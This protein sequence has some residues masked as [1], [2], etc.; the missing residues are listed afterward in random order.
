M[1]ASRLIWCLFFA[2]VCGLSLGCG[3][4]SAQS[5]AT[6]SAATHSDATEG[7]VS[8]RKKPRQVTLEE[9]G[10]SQRGGSGIKMQMHRLGAGEFD[11]S[12][13]CHASSTEGGYSVSLPNVFVDF[14]MTAIVE[15]GVEFNT[16]VVGTRDERLVKFT[17]FKMSRTDGKLKGKALEEI[18]EDFRKQGDLKE[19]RTISLGEM[20]G[21]EL[22]VTN[23]FSTAVCRAF[24]AST[25]LYS[26]VVEAPSSI[27][28]GEID[29]DVKRFLDSFAVSATAK[30]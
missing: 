3:E 4:K 18:A 23:R 7:K 21:I 19:K 17:A 25:A 28:A 6:Q 10:F 11:E 2:G 27:K 30:E 9:L 26:L 16:S 1:L 22:K 20:K 8:A 12:G 29:D 13:W 14:K 5:V 24:I 15:D